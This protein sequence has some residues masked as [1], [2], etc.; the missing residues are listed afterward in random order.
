VGGLLALETNIGRY[1][2]ARFAFLPEGK[3]TVGYRFADSVTAFAAYDFIYINRVARSAEQIDL[4]VDWVFVPFLYL[5]ETP[6]SQRGP[7][8]PAF[9]FSD[10]P[11]WAQ[12][13]TVG[14]RFGF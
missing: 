1:E 6:I 9:S 13:V 12:G 2:R 3:A 8:R 7:R 4:T 5:T 11:F 10:S 14:L